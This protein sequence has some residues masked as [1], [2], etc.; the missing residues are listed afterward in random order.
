MRRRNRDSGSGAMGKHSLPVLLG[1]GAMGK[2]SLPVLLRCCALLALVITLPASGRPP[3]GLYENGAVAADH[4]VA[5]R[6]GLEMLRKGG[7]AVDA[8]VASSFCLS[9][10]RPYSCGIGGGGF[11]VISAPPRGAAEAIQVALDYRETAPGAVGPDYYVQLGV[12]GASRHG[13]HAVGVPG[14]VAG[15]LH[16]LERY[17]TLDRATV[18]APAIRAAEEGWPA[19]ASQLGAIDDLQNRLRANP[20]LWR[21]ANYLWETMCLGGRME[22]GTILRN[23]HQARTLRQIAQGGAEAFYRGPIGQAVAAAVQ[24]GGGPLTVGDLALYEVRVMEPLRGRVRLGGRALD[25]L[26]MPPPSSGG[27][28]QLQILGIL[29]RRLGDPMPAHNGTSYVHLVA[30]AMK[31][32]FADRA[33]HLADPE[34]TEVPVGRLLEAGYLDHLATSISPEQTYGPAY[35][36]SA[37][38]L[39][40]DGGT[41]H[42]SVVDAEGMA[43][44]CSET[45]NLV[46]GSLVPVEGFGFVLN[47]QMDD[48]TSDPGRPNAFGLRQSEANA[49]E[50]GKRPLS[51][52]SPTI[53]LHEGRPLLV[54]GASGGPRII[55]ATTQCLLNCL[56]FDMPAA[57]AVAAPRFHH[58]WW[59]DR[60]QL[61]ARW[62]D[63]VTKAALEAL[64]HEVGAR[65]EIGVVQLLWVRPGG[66]DAASD[67]RKGGRP[68]GY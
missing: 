12:E 53:V 68:A 5:S 4:F 25:V 28:A 29:Q 8:A 9:V 27:V 21:S 38:Q 42:L 50:P 49:P 51:S 60:L 55:T 10:V 47:D 36:G 31:H 67:P 6:A 43:V 15:L 23:P 66:I 44:A 34:F 37:G 59:P 40:A 54:A 46:Y 65:D 17:G 61:E 11:M 64:G 58:Q 22:N 32:A 7:N 63:P 26:A 20:D 57:D 56:L 1:S 16:A 45:I 39:P 3:E 33:A 52:M 35:Y 19:D 48:F 41:S 62:R 30:E 14:T 18:L 13:H 24:A 2:H